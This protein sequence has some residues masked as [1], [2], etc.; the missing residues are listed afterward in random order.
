MIWLCGTATNPGPA[1]TPVCP[2]SGEVSRTV[3]A[4]D[5]IGPAGPGVS[6]GEFAAAATAIRTGVAY[7]NVH[8]SMF[9]GGEI[10][11][12]IKDPDRD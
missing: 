8:T 2:A 6:A 3:T 1:R 9:A 11:G 4:S 10:R 12:Q 5:V 7:S